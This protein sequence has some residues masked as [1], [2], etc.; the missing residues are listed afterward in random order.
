M[1]LLFFLSTYRHAL[2]GL[3]KNL[4]RL[5]DD[6]A[7]K[8]NSLRLD[9]QCLDVRQKLNPAGKTNVEHNLNLTGIERMKSAI[10]A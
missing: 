8:A 3:Y 1:K 9:N 5:N 7:L 4:Q 2:D 6:I 10:L